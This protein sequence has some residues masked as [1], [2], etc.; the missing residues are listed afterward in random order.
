MKKKILSVCI[1]STFMLLNVNMINEAYSQASTTSH[2]SFQGS[3]M[4]IPSGTTIAAMA[5]SELSSAYLTLGQSINLSLNQDFYYGGR[6]VAPGG[7]VVS[8]NVIQ[9]KKATHGGINGNLKIRF[10]HITTPGGQIIPISGML[11]T[12]D[13]TGLLVGSTAKDTAVAYAKDVA[14]GAG[15]GA[16]AGVIIS[17]IAGGKIGKGTALATAVGAGGG[18]AKSVW[19]KGVDAVIPCGSPISIIID[20]PITYTQSNRY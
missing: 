20:Q 4:V 19:D 11:K 2:S 18:L 17:P 14:I 6:L 13:N 10:T 9:V 1:L 8:G 3:I 12:E 5:T 16:L 7:S 15:V